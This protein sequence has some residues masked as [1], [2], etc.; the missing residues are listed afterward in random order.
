MRGTLCVGLGSG[1][2][3]DVVEEFMPEA[4]VEQVKRG[5][6]HSAVVPVDRRPIVEGFL[7]SK[8]YVVV[9]IHIAQ[10]VPR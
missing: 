2:Y 4:A 1:H 6:L 5:V 8:G 7:R 10:I 9:G 3:A